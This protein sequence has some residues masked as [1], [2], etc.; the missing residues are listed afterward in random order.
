MLFLLSF[1]LFDK[2]A[3]P[4]AKLEPLPRNG[5][6]VT[7]W[8]NPD[9]AFLD[10]ANGI[11]AV[12]EYHQASSGMQIHHPLPLKEILAASSTSQGETVAQ[13]TT[14]F[15]PRQSSTNRSRKI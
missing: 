9:E 8:S 10:I 4:F 2:H 15:Y 14:A 5:K 6:P 13:V 7:K 12:I 11:G 1:A 3:A